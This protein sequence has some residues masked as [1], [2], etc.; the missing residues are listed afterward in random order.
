MSQTFQTFPAI[1]KIVAKSACRG[2]SSANV[3]PGAGSVAHVLPRQLP[4]EAVQ[5]GPGA[6]AA[7]FAQAEVAALRRD[8]VKLHQWAERSQ[9]L[10]LGL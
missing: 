7:K 8:M 2:Q 5:V 10:L 3:H 6:S 9:R 1:L 4:A